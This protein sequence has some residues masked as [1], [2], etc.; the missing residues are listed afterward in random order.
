MSKI[1]K[2]F[3]PDKTDTTKSGCNECGELC[4]VVDDHTFGHVSEC[5]Y[6]GFVVVVDGKLVT[7]NNQV[8]F[9]DVARWL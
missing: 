9:V 8:K 2:E 7:V 1:V 5:C 3:R 4:N 6:V